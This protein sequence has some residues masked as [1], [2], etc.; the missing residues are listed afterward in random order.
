[1]EWKVIFFASGMTQAGIVAGRLEAE[2]IPTRLEYEAIG[3]IY[4][5]TLNGLGEVK[6]LVPEADME[7]ARRVLSEF[8]PQEELPWEEK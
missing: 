6:V 4:G 5:L 7:K 2:G 1:M 8:Y 3:R